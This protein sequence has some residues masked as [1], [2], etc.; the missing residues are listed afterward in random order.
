MNVDMLKAECGADDGEIIVAFFTAFGAIAALPPESMHIAVVQFAL[1]YGIDFVEEEVQ[2]AVDGL[3][4]G[5]VVEFR[6]MWP[7]LEYLLE[8]TP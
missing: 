5:G 7:V 3:Q 8:G 6:F 1:E 4:H 2:R